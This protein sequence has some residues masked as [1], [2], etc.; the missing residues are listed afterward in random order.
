MKDDRGTRTTNADSRPVVAHLVTPYLFVT[1]SWI[2]SQLVHSRRFRPIVVTQSV[3]N[4]DVFPFPDVY[5]MNGSRG[6]TQRLADLASKYALGTYPLAPYR[7]VF[8]RENV[9]IVHAHLG[10]EAART[11]GLAERSR[12]PFVVSFYGRDA[13]LL[14]RNPYWRWLYRRLFRVAD[15]V[16][17]EGHHMAGTLAEIGAPPDRIRVVHLGVDPS[18]FAFKERTLPPG[19]EPIIGLISASFREKKG[20]PFGIDAFASVQARHPRARLRIIGD[21]PLRP[22]IEER[23]RSHGLADRIDLLGYRPYP[24]YLAELSHA[25]FLL[26]P[27]V[28]AADGDSEGGAPV[29]LLDAQALG[30]PIVATTHCDIPEVT[31]PDASALLAPE[32]DVPALANRLDELLTHPERWPGMGRAGRSHIEAEFDIRRQVD[33]MADLY[34]E[35]R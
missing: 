18:A 12:R 20:I 21:G 16:I 3:E 1:G 24:E 28:T 26:S 14:V 2:H 8:D 6:R 4:R 22:A 19:D 23:I 34:E 31:R 32:R 33:R 27:S 30:V 35:L 9:R 13:T 15:R 10:W 5:E 11:A 17:A 7:R 29:C 25:H